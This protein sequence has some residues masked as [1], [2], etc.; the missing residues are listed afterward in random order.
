MRLLN[1]YIQM[2]PVIKA[3]ESLAA[4]QVGVC[5]GGPKSKRQAQQMKRQVKDWQKT[6]MR[7]SGRSTVRRPVSAG[8]MKAVMAG[9]GISVKEVPARG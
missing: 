3:E 1:C 9:F 2:L 6:M 5:A 8:D 4:Y 7:H